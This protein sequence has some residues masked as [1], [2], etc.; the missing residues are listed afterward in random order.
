[1][2]DDV[3]R[4]YGILFFL[5]L[6]PKHPATLVCPGGASPASVTAA[7]RNTRRLSLAMTHDSDSH[8]RVHRDELEQKT[9]SEGSRENIK[10]HCRGEWQLHTF[11]LIFWS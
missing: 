11:C 7:L 3:W 2:T 4:M 9:L 1:M 5:R 6:R 8:D 10:Q